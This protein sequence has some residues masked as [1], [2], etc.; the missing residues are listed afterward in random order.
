[1]GLVV[2]GLDGVV[3]F[4]KYIITVRMYRFNVSKYIKLLRIIY[5][6]QFKKI[7]KI[8]IRIYIFIYSLNMYLFFSRMHCNNA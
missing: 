2:G 3:N 5:V 6:F 1:M 7:N 4:H 8:I